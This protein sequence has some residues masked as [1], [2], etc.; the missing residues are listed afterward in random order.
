MTLH[1]LMEYIVES[2]LKELKVRDP[3]LK[4]CSEMMT[5]DILAITLNNLPPKYV[6]TSKGEMY[7]K[8]QVT[9][10]METDVYRELS[11][12][13][14]KVQHSKRDSAFKEEADD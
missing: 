8:S 11:K 4:N 2:I 9:K 3:R 14:E 7:A 6:V 10:Q 1:N 5:N 12:A 13:I